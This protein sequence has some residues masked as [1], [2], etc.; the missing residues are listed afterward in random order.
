MFLQDILKNTVIGKIE[1]FASVI[2]EDVSFTNVGA[3]KWQVTISF[4]LDS[5]AMNPIE[6]EA[7]SAIMKYL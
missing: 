7:L 2:K 4:D 3:N 5:T 6:K 1:G